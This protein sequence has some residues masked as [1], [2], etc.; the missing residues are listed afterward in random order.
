VARIENPLAVK[1]IEIFACLLISMLISESVSA[2]Q[3][4]VGLDRF[5]RVRVFKK[6]A[7]GRIG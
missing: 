4:P 6:N 3:W 1:L 5:G 2:E 7:L